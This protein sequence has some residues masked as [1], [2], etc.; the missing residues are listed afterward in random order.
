M[1]PPGSAADFKRLIPMVIIRP[2]TY[3]QQSYNACLWIPT[4]HHFSFTRQTAACREAVGATLHYTAPPFLMH[5][6]C[7]VG[8]L[9]HL[10]LAYSNVLGTRETTQSA[11][12]PKER[13]GGDP[14]RW[15]FPRVTSG[16]GRGLA[17]HGGPTLSDIGR[18]S[19]RARG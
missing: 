18:V 12:L 6:C 9:A 5:Q 1:F 8:L 11:S 2:S 17:A 13:R 10:W 7:N 3:V 14:M 15:V 16:G 19:T 4:I